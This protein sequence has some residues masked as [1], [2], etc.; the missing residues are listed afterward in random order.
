MTK[1]KKKKKKPNPTPD[2]Q[3]LTTE[4]KLNFIKTECKNPKAQ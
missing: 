4:K 2:L 1:T 3:P